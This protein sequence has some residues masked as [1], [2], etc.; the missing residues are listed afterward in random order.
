MSFNLGNWHILARS[1][2]LIYNTQ[3]RIQPFVKHVLSI[4]KCTRHYFNNTVLWRAQKLKK[5][6]HRIEVLSLLL[7]VLFYCLAFNYKI[8]ISIYIYNKYI[9][10]S[11]SLYLTIKGFEIKLHQNT[12]LISYVAALLNQIVMFCSILYSVNFKASF[13]K[14]LHLPP[15]EAVKSGYNR[16]FRMLEHTVNTSQRQLLLKFYWYIYW[17]SNKYQ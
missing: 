11:L 8:Y 13:S 9:Y 1:P 4:F 16:N 6:Q 15:E 17:H 7:T 12:H 2:R 5:K 10:I 14:F 3:N